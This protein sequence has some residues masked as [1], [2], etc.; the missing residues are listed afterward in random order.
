MRQV[1]APLRLDVYDIDMQRHGDAEPDAGRQ[2]IQNRGRADEHPQEPGA[3]LVIQN[4]RQT[5]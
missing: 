2:S 5:P 1:A 3:D 4:M